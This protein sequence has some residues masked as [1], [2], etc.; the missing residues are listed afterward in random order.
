M[1]LAIDATSNSN[2]SSSPLTWSHTCAG[3]ERLLVVSVALN[4]GSSGSV[5]GVTYNGAALTPVGLAVGDASDD[6]TSRKRP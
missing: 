4:P 6:E 2:S 5:S 3:A 1:A